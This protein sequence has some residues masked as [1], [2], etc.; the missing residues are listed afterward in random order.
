MPSTRRSLEA[1]EY[2]G[3]S[4]DDHHDETRGRQTPQLEQWRGV[5]PSN[6]GQ[7]GREDGGTRRRTY[8]HTR[9]RISAEHYL[10]LGCRQ[11][12]NL[13]TGLHDEEGKCK[14]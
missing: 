13:T 14:E 4:G 8:R 9:S 2:D 5:F 10:E 6:S 1:I 11:R 3:G 12:G 7:G